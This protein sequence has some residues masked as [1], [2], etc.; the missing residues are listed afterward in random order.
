MVLHRSMP[1]IKLD[2]RGLISVCVEALKHL[3]PQSWIYSFKCVNLYPTH[4]ISFE[5]W[6]KKIEVDIVAG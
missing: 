6:L 2:Q 1:R 3:T 4:Q 5:V